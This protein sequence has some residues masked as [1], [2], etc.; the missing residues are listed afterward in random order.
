MIKE[1]IEY[2]M[3]LKHDP[4]VNVNE[5]NYNV[6]IN[7]NMQHIKEPLQT[8][9]QVKNLTGLIDYI[10]YNPDGINITD[11]FILI[12]DYHTVSLISK[13]LEPWKERIRYIQAVYDYPQIIFDDFVELEKFIIMLKSTFIETE[14][15][16][17]LVKS[18]S[19]VV[20]GN[21][22]TNEDDGI[23]QKVTV[24]TGIDL[25]GYCYLKPIITLIPRRTFTEAEQPIGNYFFRI[26]KSKYEGIECALFVADGGD[27]KNQ[28]ISNIRDY[29][30]D[31]LPNDFIILA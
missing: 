25:K 2:L 8:S 6:D 31:H 18:L 1:A 17:E 11:Q 23:T 3:K 16:N 22:K 13:P 30:I 9:I 28:A 19:K 15:L 14:E 20:D 26:R 7:G 21:I 24:S 29:L 4:V 12:E 27:W 5:R 10:N